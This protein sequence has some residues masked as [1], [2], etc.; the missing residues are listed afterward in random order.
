MKAYRDGQCVATAPTGTRTRGL[1]R[2][3]QLRHYL[4]R[5]RPVLARFQAFSACEFHGMS[6]PMRLIL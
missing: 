3:N 5:I 6:S 4:D 2:M 1:T